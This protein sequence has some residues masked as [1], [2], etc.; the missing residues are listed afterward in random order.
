MDTMTTT[1]VE[2]LITECLQLHY[3]VFYRLAY[4]YVRNEQ[5]AMDIVQESIYKAMKHCHELREPQY[6]RTWLYQIVRNESISFLRKNKYVSVPLVLA[7][8]EREDD[9]PDIDLQCAIGQLDVREK[10]V[11][12]LRFFEGLSFQ[13]I[14]ETLQENINTIKSRLYRALQKLRLLLDEA[15]AMM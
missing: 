9:Y 5:D 8:G 6:M 3:P 4:S 14:A 12:L 7:D 13:Q 1:T 2:Q 11:V 10:T 15:Y